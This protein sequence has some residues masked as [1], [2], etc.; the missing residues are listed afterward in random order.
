MTSFDNIQLDMFQEGSCTPDTLSRA[1]LPSQ[2]DSF[3]VMS[4][5]DVEYFIHTLIESL[6][7]NKDCLNVY[8]QAQASDEICFKLLLL[9][10]H[11]DQKGS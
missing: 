4:A 3:D 5:A 11:T 8:H 10:L 9:G 6:P 2:L 1:P 7:A